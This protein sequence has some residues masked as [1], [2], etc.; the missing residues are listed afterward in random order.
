MSIT[1]TKAGIALRKWIKENGFTI[2]KTTSSSGHYLRVDNDGL[3]IKIIW[4][5]DDDI[6]KGNPGIMYYVKWQSWTN[7]K[8]NIYLECETDKHEFDESH[9]LYDVVDYIKENNDN[10][11]KALKDNINKRLKKLQS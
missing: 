1:I 7:R 4:H 2:I 6:D 3:S 10:M 9:V 11:I 8:D 5:Y